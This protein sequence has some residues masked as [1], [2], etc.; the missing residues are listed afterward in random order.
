MY[1]PGSYYCRK[2]LGSPSEFLQSLNHFLVII[3]SPRNE[4]YVIVQKIIILQFVKLMVIS[5]DFL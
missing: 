1:V 4:K 5:Q 3:T 2:I